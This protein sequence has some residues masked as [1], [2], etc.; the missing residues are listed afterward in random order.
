MGADLANPSADRRKGRERSKNTFGLQP[1]SAP[2]SATLEAA[3]LVS[4]ERIGALDMKAT[5]RYICIM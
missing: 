5:T 3:V 4:K 2:S 1:P